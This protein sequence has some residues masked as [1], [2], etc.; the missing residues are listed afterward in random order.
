MRWHCGRLLIS[1]FRKAYI[2]KAP[3]DVSFAWTDVLFCLCEAYL[4]QY[5]FS[6]GFWQWF[7]APQLGWT[8]CVLWDMQGIQFTRWT[9]VPGVGRFGSW[10]CSSRRVRDYVCI[11]RLATILC[12]H[13]VRIAGKKTRDFFILSY[14][15]PQI[16]QKCRIHIKF[17]GSWRV[18]RSK[19]H[20]EDPQSWSD[21]WPSLS[22]DAFCSVHV[23]RY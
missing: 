15:G 13:I 22:L 9:K 2:E 10:L 4:M 1:I 12:F 23:K 5:L 16:S 3:N 11:D 8:W 18:I 14:R 7:F 21:P 19:F 20:A 6:E 17:V